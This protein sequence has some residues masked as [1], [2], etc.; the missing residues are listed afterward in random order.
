MGMGWVQVQ[1]KR[2]ALVDS[3]S[4]FRTGRR[5]PLCLG[6]GFLRRHVHDGRDWTC[7][8]RSVFVSGGGEGNVRPVS[9]RGAREKREKRACRG[10]KGEDLC[11]ALASVGL[12]VS[13]SV[14]ASAS[15]CVF[16]EFSVYMVACIVLLP[17]PCANGGQGCWGRGEST[18]GKQREDGRALTRW[19]DGDEA[20][21]ALQ[22]G[23]VE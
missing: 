10:P 13:A 5:Q 7:S 18:D 15:V 4:E 22:L 6:E 12:C 16:G 17:T 9:V 11:A 3:R 23:R 20:I 19:M 8:N 14:G 21:D 1:P 2:T